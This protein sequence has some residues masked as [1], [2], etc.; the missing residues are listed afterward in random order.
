MDTLP[1][2]VIGMRTLSE[3]AALDVI[4]DVISLPK[5]FAAVNVT[6]P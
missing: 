6:F 2:A 4:E 5:Y 3:H 1:P